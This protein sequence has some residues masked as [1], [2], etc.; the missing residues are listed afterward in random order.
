MFSDGELNKWQVF[1]T[2]KQE[3]IKFDQSEKQEMKK[4]A[5]Q[6][7]P[8]FHLIFRLFWTPADITA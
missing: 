4:V 1:K 5:K 7:L 6:V 3:T 8:P 2:E